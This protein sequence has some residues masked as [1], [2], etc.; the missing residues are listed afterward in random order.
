M[1]YT[2]QNGEN[3]VV[4]STNDK[5]EALI[6]AKLYSRGTLD[7][8]LCRVS[9]VEEEGEDAR[10]IAIFESGAEFRRAE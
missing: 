9:V 6:F 5:T 3:L 4:A 7:F 10:T 8:P 2:I 1:K